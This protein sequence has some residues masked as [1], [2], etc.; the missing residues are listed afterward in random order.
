MTPLTSFLTSAGD[1]S[2]YT[3]NVTLPVGDSVESA[4]WTCDSG[5][6]IHG[7]PSG[8]E[9]FV[10]PT[11]ATAWITSGASTGTFYAYC[12]ITSQ[13]G[14]VRNVSIGIQIA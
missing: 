3:I 4:V 11:T 12:E 9:T 2:P 7:A 14:L 6:S 8:P 1:V 10:T 13:L 5:I